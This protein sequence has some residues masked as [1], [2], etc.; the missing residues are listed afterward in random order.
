MS[1]NSSI[2]TGFV[3]ESFGPSHLDRIEAIAR[4]PDF[5]AIGIEF[6]RHSRAYQWEQGG[7]GSAER[8]SLFNSDKQPG[9][10]ALA[11][12]LLRNLW[13]SPVRHVFLCHYNYPPVF[14]A[15]VVLRLGGRRVYAMLDS[16]YD[17]YPRSAPRE[18]F[19]RLLLAPY[20]GALVASRRSVEYVRYLGFRQRP[21]AQGFDSLDVARLQAAAAGARDLPH[22]ERDFLIVARLVGKKNL[23]FALRAFAA[24]RAEARHPR[25]LRIVGYGE[26]E[27]E[28]RQLAE[29]L[30]IAAEVIFTGA[31]DSLA[32]A[33][34]MAEAL[35]LILPSTEEQFGLVVIEALAQGLPALVSSNAGAVD[36][37]VDPGGNG[38]VID[39]HRLETLTA[40]MALLDRDEV[41]WQSARAAAFASCERGDVRHFVAGVRALVQAG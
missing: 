15:A 4:E 1:E 35:C 19:K 24:H 29:E 6:N 5:R 34:A 14:L 23:P 13:R 22:A 33:R 38:W 12:Q 41:A 21:V 18:W 32:V 36:E 37:L 30:G 9:Q 3:W 20:H 27:A 11:W 2:A 16:K 25:R 26:Q 10:A 28:L 31:L 7:G 40:A 39:P 17:D 8:I